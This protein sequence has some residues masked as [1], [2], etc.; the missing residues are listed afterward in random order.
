MKK[1]IAAAEFQL[2]QLNPRI[3]DKR[4]KLSKIFQL[5]KMGFGLEQLRYLLNTIKEIAKENNIHASTAVEKFLNELDYY[6]EVARFQN[7]LKQQREE[8]NKLSIQIAA[9]RSNLLAHQYIGPVLQSLLAKGVTENDI[10]DI[11]AILSLIEPDYFNRNP[12][13]QQLIQDL[14][15][16]KNLKKLIQSLEQHKINL[17][18]DSSILENHKQQLENFINFYLF[19]FLSFLGDLKSSLNRKSY[20]ENL[21]QVVFVCILNLPKD[22]KSS[23]NEEKKEGEKQNDDSENDNDQENNK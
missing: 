19:F 10:I 5:E 22:T 12:R 17:E 11:N 14:E 1:D 18:R 13:K 21:F 23:T 3:N 8:S 4:L 9:A 2:A 15:N 6:E 7:T 20:Y 16:Y